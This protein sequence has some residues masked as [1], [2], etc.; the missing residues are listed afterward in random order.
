MWKKYA[1]DQRGITLI[2]MMV[3][4]VILGILATIIFTRVSDR[5]EQARRTKAAVEI[6][7][8]Q[9]ALELFKLDN[10]FFPSTEQGLEALVSIPTT[11]KIP[12]NYPESGYLEKVPR[13]PWGNPYV[14]ICPGAHG[15]YDL[16][17]YGA[18]GE[19]GGDGKN[20]DVESWNLD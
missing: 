5:P 1:R 7:Q 6:R 16:V 17:S 11:G 20:R 9:T 18:D 19:P 12:T 15:D 4:I 10:G 3:V 8:I 2:E 13:D 14:Y